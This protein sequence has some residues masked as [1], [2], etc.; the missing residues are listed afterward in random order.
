[1]WH[2]HTPY[3][4]LESRISNDSSQN[5]LE[6]LGL[7]GFKNQCFSWNQ[8]SGSYSPGLMTC[9]NRRLTNGAGV[10]GAI[11]ILVGGF[12]RSFLDHCWTIFA[13]VWLCLYHFDHFVY[14]CKMFCYFF[15]SIKKVPSWQRV[16]VLV[17]VIFAF[18]SRPLF[19]NIN[20]FTFPS[21]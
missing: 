11:R 5:F 3:W 7:P 20:F 8:L 16:V 12:V 19:Q 13:H 21:M 10:K 18:F 17:V 15:V 2:I 14:F 6:Y 1:M 9:V 4:R